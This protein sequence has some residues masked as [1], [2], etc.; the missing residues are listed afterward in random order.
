MDSPQ[1]CVCGEEFISDECYKYHKVHK[2]CQ[3]Y[4]RCAECKVRYEVRWGK[5]KEKGEPKIELKHVCY[6]RFC[7]KCLG[8]FIEILKKT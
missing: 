1:K 4:K 3:K 5:P 8:N 2:I 6:E 7:K